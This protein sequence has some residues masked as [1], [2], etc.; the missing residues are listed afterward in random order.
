[1][2]PGII[3]SSY[4]KGSY[5]L[6][7]FTGSYAAYS[8]RK[9]S[10][11]Y[12]G[13]CM[14]VVRDKDNAEL[15]INF[16]GGKLDTGSI[17]NFI[18]DEENLFRYSEPATD[19]GT[20][21]RTNVLFSANTWGTITSASSAASIS[22]EG[23]VTMRPTASVF[24]SISYGGQAGLSY[25]MYSIS[26]LSG[27]T[28]QVVFG[29]STGDYNHIM[30]G[31]TPAIFSSQ[32]LGNGYYL[33]RSVF[34]TTS[35]TLSSNYGPRKTSTNTANSV[36]VSGILLTSGSTNYDFSTYCQNYIKTI[37]ST[38]GAGRVATW[39]DQSGNNRHLTSS[40][41]TSQPHIIQI[42]SATGV[43]SFPT[44][45]TGFVGINQS[46]VSTQF[47]TMVNFAPPS[48]TYD[49]QVY[50]HLLASSQTLYMSY[51]NNPSARYYGL[52]QSGSANVG[53]NSGAGTVNYKV[54]NANI[55]GS[56]RGQGMSQIYPPIGNPTADLKLLTAANA[57]LSTWVEYDT[58][59]K[60]GQQSLNNMVEKIMFTGSYNSFTSSL[61]SKVNTYYNIY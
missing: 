11:T 48:S 43:K 4:I 36:E 38:A 22:F 44:S 51:T 13:P 14:K 58:K 46:A 52:F 42:N 2:N 31:G 33:C 53:F 50:N 59:L 12:T 28:N 5:I 10:S 57:N 7:Q 19:P 55:T 17:S 18:G 54:N 15:D 37:G 8:L 34:T 40:A 24:T 61:E 21:T 23:T 35:T 32:S 49:M 56:T 47:M 6:N 30:A 41:Q 9:L 16:V 60:T 27:S 25:T 45:S 20:G 29:T 39:Y 3:A 1:M 26:K